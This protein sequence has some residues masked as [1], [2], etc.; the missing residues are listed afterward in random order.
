METDG[1]APVR[2]YIKSLSTNARAKFYAFIDYVA[3]HGP[4][5]KRPYA[6][7]MGDGS[8]LYELRPKPHRAIY[9]FFQRDK[10]V[11]LHSFEK[12]TQKIKEEDMKIAKNRMRRCLEK[13]KISKVEKEEGS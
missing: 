11:F 12:T 5:A 1:S 3:D 4:Q 9:F 6:D 8:K 10:V 2:V 13:G 7:Y